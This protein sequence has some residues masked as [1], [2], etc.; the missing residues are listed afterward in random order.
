MDNHAILIDCGVPYNKLKQLLYK[1]KFLFITHIHS[2]HLKKTTYKRIRKEFPRI[3]VMGNWQV[4]QELQDYMGDGVDLITVNG[5]EYN[6][7]GYTF[8]PFECPHHGIE[9]QG[10]V[11]NLKD[12]RRVI[13]ATDTSTLSHAPDGQY[14]LLLLEANHDPVKVRMA[15]KVKGYDPLL[16]S[17]RHLSKK[18]SFDFYLLRRKS[19]ESE[20]VELH[21]SERFY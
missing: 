21:K 7:K 8:N 13:Y 16:N 12:G 2:D 1:T 14:D 4:H 19:P 5:Q 11:F 6:M 9:C 10:L 18:D 20:Y 17:M 3:T 15:R